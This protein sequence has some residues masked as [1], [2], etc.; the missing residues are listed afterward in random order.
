[1][2]IAEQMRETERKAAAFFCEEG[3]SCEGF[4]FV[5]SD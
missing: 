4:S 5:D 2:Y 1:M 3:Y